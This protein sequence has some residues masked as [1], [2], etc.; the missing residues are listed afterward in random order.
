MPTAGVLIYTRTAGYRHDSLLAAAAA[1][2]GL[3]RE[4]GWRAD[5]TDDPG[6]FTP[7][8]LAGRPAVVLLSTTG[9]VLTPGGRTAFEAY[10][11]GGGALLAVHAAANAE[12]DWPF[13]GELLGTRFAG[14]PALQPGRVLVE[15]PGHPATAPLPAVLEW[16]DEWYDFTSPPRAAGVH[17]LARV[18]ESSYEGGTHGD[19]H[20]LVWCRA[21]DRGRFLFTA[22]GHAAEAYEDPSFRAHLGGA[23]DWLTA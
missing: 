16:T 15:D 21:V 1:L 7:E 23:L 22:L 2:A 17:V 11:R 3:A 20:P 19:D 18:D 13:Y 14:H 10:L 6:A 12:P 4:R 8:G 9:T 5:V